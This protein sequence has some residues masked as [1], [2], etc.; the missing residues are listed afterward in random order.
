MLKKV[1]Y[2]LGAQSVEMPFDLT[3]DDCESHRVE[4][5]ELSA[6]N[7]GKSAGGKPFP[8]GRSGN[9]GGRP[10]VDPNVKEA[11]SAASPV[12]AARLIQLVRS[13][14]E[15]VA[16]KA[17]MAVLDRVYGKPTQ[18]VEV[19]E[20]D[21]LTDEQ[22]EARYRALVSSATTTATEPPK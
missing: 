21:S 12:A 4:G 10:K 5:E 16:L 3:Q 14:D 7:S 15:D 20:L 17:S 8:K 11:L 18:K 6:Q 9:P 2:D 1:A 19:K 22:L 13:D